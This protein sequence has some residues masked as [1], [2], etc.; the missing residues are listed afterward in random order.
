MAL[1]DASWQAAAA[2]HLL[3][4]RK[5]NGRIG[6]RKSRG[7]C[8]TC[9]S[10]RV[11]CDEERPLCHRC[12]SSGRKCE[13][14]ADKTSVRNG[15]FPVGVPLS[16]FLALREQ[17]KRTF[18]YF[19]S[20]TAPRLAGM[21][22]K[23]FWCGQIL[24]LAQAEPLVLDSLLAIS[25]LY[26]HPQ[27]MKDFHQH[28][29][30]GVNLIEQPVGDGMKTPALHSGEH[31]LPLD[32][33]HADALRAYNRAI[34]QFRQKM[35]DGHATPLL[36]LISCVL[37]IC[38]EVIRDDV[39]A[40]LALFSKGSDLLKRF[41]DSSFTSD[42]Q[43]LLLTIKLMFARLGVLAAA[44]GH[45]HPLD[46]PLEFVVVGQRSVFAN[47]ADARTALYALMADS[48]VF[49]RDAAAYKA[50]VFISNGRAAWE[51]AMGYD[52]STGL[53]PKAET[54]EDGMKET[55]VAVLPA[56]VNV[57]T[58]IGLTEDEPVFYDESASIQA[59]PWSHQRRTKLLSQQDG[60]FGVM[61]CQCECE[62]TTCIC[63][64]KSRR[65]MTADVQEKRQDVMA[66]TATVLKDDHW[67]L[68]DREISLPAS[69]DSLLLQQER[70]SKRLGQ[71]YDAFQ[72]AKGNVESL[73][74][75]ATSNLLLYYHVS[76]IWLTTRMA[77]WQLVF[78]EYT[79]HFREILRHAERYVA[80]KEQQKPVFTFEVGAVPPLYFMA[81]KCRVPS[82]RRKAL[83]L[84]ARAPRKECMWGAT[85]TGQLAARVI[86]IEEEGL[87]LPPP[88]WNGLSLAD[89]TIL[90]DT[91]AAC[92]VKLPAERCRLQNLELLKNMP[93]HTFE[94]RVTRYD[95]DARGELR[96]VTKDYPI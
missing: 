57:R 21:L 56:T 35:A 44:F 59:L 85:S 47:L 20:W 1:E 4:A 87:G 55:S 9:K 18:E 62:E 86:A 33:H 12:T 64:R 79:Y 69:L 58:G 83:R 84:L 16:Q 78:D 15:R 43:E 52:L 82:L 31:N 63:D 68:P 89:A 23:N 5:R 51:S 93:N 39:F 61:E 53:H 90:E 88:A 37:F 25:K 91:H 17:D 70:M 71:W 26:E 76:Y 94:I 92:D 41:S 11:K 42:E 95:V 80:V 29:R 49:I 19:I 27:Y 77:P 38:I 13:G 6:S 81:T 36:A 22:D 8:V 30:E 3:E 54:A 34:D 45:P 14:Y 72:W 75:E 10:R 60:M 73:E 32:V 50:T 7:G 46:V 65:A 48:H 2:S 67:P 24:Q 96:Q 40:A 74:A 28:K 66:S